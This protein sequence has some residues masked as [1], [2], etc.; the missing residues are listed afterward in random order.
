LRRRDLIF[1]SGA[2]VLLPLGARPG[3]G[4]A[5]A[6]DVVSR[7]VAAGA[8]PVAGLP[9]LGANVPDPFLLNNGLRC[10][11]KADWRVRRAELQEIVQACCY[12]FAPEMD[13]GTKVVSRRDTTVVAGIVKS[14]FV[15]T[16][17]PQHCVTFHFNLY[18][19]AGNVTPLPV[20]M[21][22]EL[23]WANLDATVGTSNIA[24]GMANIERLVNGL[25]G[26]KYIVGEMNRDDFAYDAADDQSAF[27]KYPAINSYPYGSGNGRYDWG[28]LR[29]WAWGMSRVIDALVTFA[30]VDPAKISIAG[31]SRGGHAAGLAGALDERIALTVDC[32]GGCVLEPWRGSKIKTPPPGALINHNI[33]YGGAPGWHNA[34]FADFNGAAVNKLPYDILATLIAP[35]LFLSLN[36]DEDANLDQLKAAQGFNCAKQVYLALGVPEAIGFWTTAKAG[37][38]DTVLGHNMEFDKWVAWQNFADHHWHGVND[39]SPAYDFTTAPSRAPYTSGLPPIYSWAPPALT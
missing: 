4:T 24:I 18:Q 6:N 14:E 23:G 29:A 26:N 1:L 31:L 11:T 21:S 2:A 8:I 15:C 37:R 34:R 25:N 36:N 16:T 20:L 9:D 13:T 19:P 22:S 27:T 7:N 30:A 5:S 39:Y 12:G 33:V 28:T 35:R 38:N 10:G 32:M 3:Q 17:G